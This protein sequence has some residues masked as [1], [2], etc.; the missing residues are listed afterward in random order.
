MYSKK[1][2]SGFTLIELMITVAIIAILAAVAIPSYQQYV[3]R[4]KRAAAQAQMMEIANRQQQYFLANRGYASKTD[5]QS[6]GYALPGEVS[7]SYGYDIALNTVLNA[8]CASVA[9]TVPSFVITFAPTTT[10]GQQGDGNLTLSSEG[11]KCPAGKW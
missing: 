2:S 3:V 10:G 8:S 5:L 1:N 9:S 11:V 4:G 7:A 6:S